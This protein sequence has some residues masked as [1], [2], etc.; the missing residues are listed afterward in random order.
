M[1]LRGSQDGL[2]EELDQKDVQKQYD[3]AIQ[4]L[5]N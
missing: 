3:S 1:I 5:K 4:A 2:P